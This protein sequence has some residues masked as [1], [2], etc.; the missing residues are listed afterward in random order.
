ML[1][2]KPCIEMNNKFTEKAKNGF[3]KDYFKLMSNVI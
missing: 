2:K 3:E 1:F